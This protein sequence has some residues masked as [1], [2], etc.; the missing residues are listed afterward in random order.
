MIYKNS[1]KILFSNFDIV[2]K[3]ILYYILVFLITG[4]L[5]Y[6]CI[7]PIY[8]L[9]SAG[10]LVTDFLNVYSDFLSNLNLTALFTSINTL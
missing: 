5:C 8:K 9:L 1:I 3:N 10:G 2:W 4:G 6:I 7:N